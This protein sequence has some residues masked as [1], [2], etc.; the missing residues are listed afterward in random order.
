[1]NWT[2]GKYAHQKRNELSLNKDNIAVFLL[3][4]IVYINN[5]AWRFDS[6]GECLH[7]NKDVGQ[8][9]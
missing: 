6:N 1:M 8:R 7:Q 3:F 5:L 9:F 2:Q 4:S